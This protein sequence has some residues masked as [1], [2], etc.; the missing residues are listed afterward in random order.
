MRMD[1]FYAIHTYELF[2]SPLQQTYS[3]LFIKN[4]KVFLK[5]SKALD[6]LPQNYYNNNI[7]L[8]QGKIAFSVKWLVPG[9][10]WCEEMRT[11]KRKSMARGG[12]ERESKEKGGMKNIFHF[13]QM[14]LNGLGKAWKMLLSSTAFG[15][16]S[17]S[18]K[19]EN[20]FFF[21]SFSPI[22]PDVRGLRIL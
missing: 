10:F 7:F 4:N 3:T 21:F 8:G 20:L 13:F 1:G 14:P 6:F 5:N 12:K 15:I 17:I 16:Q 11:E 18:K 19:K 9:Y 2:D 22:F